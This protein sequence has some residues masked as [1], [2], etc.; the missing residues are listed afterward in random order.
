MVHVDPSCPVA[1]RPLTGEL[2]L[3]ASLDYEKITRYELVIKARDQGIPPRS[4]NITVVLNV[5]D[6]NDN[7][8]QF[9]MHL[10]I[11][12]VVYLGTRY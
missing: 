12:E 8:P 3:S 1:V 2:A 6:V 11:V 4:S 5:I 10:Y 7:A 9:D